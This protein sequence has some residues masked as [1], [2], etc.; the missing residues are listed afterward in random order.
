MLSTKSVVVS[1]PSKT[2][3]PGNQTITINSVVLE[4]QTMKP[5]AKHLILNVEGP[6]L[7]E[8]FE[9]FFIDKNQPDLGRHKGSTGK[10]KMS[11]FPYADHKTETLD[12]KRDEEIMKALKR[13][14]LA[15]GLQEWYDGEDNKHDTIDSLVEQFN[16]DKPFKGIAL[17]VCLAGSKYTNKG[18]YENYDLFFPKPGKGKVVFELAGTN[19]GKLMAYEPTVH[20]KTRKPKPATD[21]SEGE[22][23][24]P[25]ESFGKEDAPVT[26]AKKAKI[27]KTFDL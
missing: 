7:G 4:D 1:G 17:D 16:T 14:C 24:K 6:D 3:D 8:G 10:V 2:L 18:G 11:D 25:V 22:I 23:V 15:L 12:I 5:G 26:K 13:L 27:D 21:A 9:G 19:S 20:L